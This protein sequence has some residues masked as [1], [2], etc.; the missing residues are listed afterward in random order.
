MTRPLD[1]PPGRD[2]VPSL[3]AGS[4]HPPLRVLVADD[5]DLVRAGLITLLQRDPSLVV[6]AQARTGVEAITLARAEKPDVVVI[7]IR[8]PELDGI[9]ATR[10][11]RALPELAA[12]RVLVLTTFDDDEELFAAL[13]AGAAGFLTKDA[14]PDEL[15]AAVRMVAAGHGLLAPSATT[16]VI[17]RAVG[18]SR[19]DPDIATRVATLTERERDVLVEVARGATNQELAERLVLSPATTRTYV[20]RLL[21]KLDARDRVALVIMAFRAGLL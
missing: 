1:E 15:R 12:T 10:Q 18:S 21:A 4:G 9:T 5:Q 20:S 11:I 13:D 19:I 2:A 14:E 7:D 6:V 8:M 3:A 17:R 16:R